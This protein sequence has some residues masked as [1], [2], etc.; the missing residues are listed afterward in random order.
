MRYQRFPVCSCDHAVDLTCPCGLQVWYPSHGYVNSCDGGRGHSYCDY[1][2]RA[3][4]LPSNSRGQ[5]GRLVRGRTSCKRRGG[6]AGQG[7]VRHGESRYSGVWSRRLFVLFVR[8]GCAQDTKHTGP[9]LA[10]CPPTGSS[11]EHHQ[12]GVSLRK[13]FGTPQTLIDHIDR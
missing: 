5:K 9:D 11:K 8:G 4:Q 7:I 2:F 3:R 1:R 12:V 6:G 13:S 10:R